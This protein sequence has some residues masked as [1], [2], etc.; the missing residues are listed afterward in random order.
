M[1]LVPGRLDRAEQEALVEAVREVVAAAPLFVPTMPRSA[2]PFS[3]RMTNAGPLGWV[4]DVSGY[5]YQSTHPETG[6][7]WPPIPPT[8][9][10][11]WQEVAPAAA[12]PEACL[13]NLYGPEARMGLHQ[14]R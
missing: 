1:R 4:S 9:L 7:P 13:V 12:P 6:Q 5:R 14:D 10:A 11:L 2:K 8:L 3:V